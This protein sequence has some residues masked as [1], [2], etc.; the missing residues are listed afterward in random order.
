MPSE[1]RVVGFENCRKKEKQEV[2][3]KKEFVI[4]SA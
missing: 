1:E 3:S 4:D 2:R